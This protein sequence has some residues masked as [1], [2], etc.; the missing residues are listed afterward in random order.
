MGL[1]DRLKKWKRV[2]DNC[3]TYR[4]AVCFIIF[5]LFVV[6]F[7]YPNYMTRDDGKHAFKLEKIRQC[8]EDRLIT[9]SLDVEEGNANV[10]RNLIGD[11]DDSF[12]PFVGNG[13]H[14]VTITPLSTIYLKKLRTLSL[15]LKW[16]P[17]YNIN[18]D[19]VMEEVVVSNFLNGVVHRYQCLGNGLHVTY[20]YISHRLR[21]YLFMQEL[22]FVNPSSQKVNLKLSKPNLSLWSH[23]EPRITRIPEGK[24]KALYEITSG[25][26]DIDKEK[27]ELAVSI[28][29]KSIPRALEIEP[30]RTKI[31]QIP[32][33]IYSEVIPKGSYFEKRNNIETKSVEE[34]KNI[35]MEN[36]N[37]IKM[38]HINAW[39]KVW[40]TGLFISHSKAANALNGDKINATIYYVLS[41]VLPLS[42]ISN[43]KTALTKINDNSYLTLAEGCYGGYHHTL[44]A[45]KLWKSLN[46]Y[47]EV[48]DIVS[49]WLL[50]LEK[51]GCQKLIS[52]GYLRVMQAL[53]LSFGGFRFNSH[54]LEFKIDP[55]FLHR[56][57][58]FRRI[59]YDGITNINVSVTLQDDNKA[60]LGVSL[61]KS[62]KNYYACDGGCIEEPVK[63]GTS[64][65]Y[66][67]VKMTEPITSILYITS[68]KSHMELIKHTLHVH[69]IVEAPAYDHHVIALHRH[70]H[71]LGGLPVLFWASICFLIV[72]F[73]LFLFK[74][75]FNEYCDKPDRH[76]RVRY[77]KI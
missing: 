29:L 56:D 38:E 74:L 17:L 21:P 55:K 60:L 14:G 70:G 73:H 3:M 39:T 37:K 66:F 32:C 63:L 71:H 68:D 36:F 65:I 10:R 33:I 72:I 50:T 62:D 45:K 30:H 43:N 12:L 67:P 23:T 18:T 34:L 26:V 19:S 59:S 41:N 51:Q 57:F 61:D 69:K 15:D 53:I 25:T 6:I 5:L 52:S 64:V 9:F 54:H 11:K 31:I 24:G 16:S 7:V 76:S 75:I 47:E 35:T 58:I 44:Q 22:K 46:T 27:E 28:I 77:G 2:P 49:L 20:N 40:E 1:T 4:K 42:V 48:N 8:L 13:Y